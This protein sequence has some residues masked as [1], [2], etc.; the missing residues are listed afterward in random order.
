MFKGKVVIVTGSSSGIGAGTAIKYAKEGAA[1]VVLHG[2][3]Q[4]QLEKVKKDCEAASH[5]QGK[6]HVVVGDISDPKVQEKLVNETVKL[7]GQ[8]DVLVNNAGISMQ[9]TPT[10]ECPIDV[11]DNLF[12]INVRSLILTTQLAIPHLV[13]TKGSIVNIS[14]VAALKAHPVFTYYNMTKI[15]VDHYTRC[16]AVE[17]GPQGVRVNSVQP[18]AIP[19]TD[20]AARSLA[21]APDFEQFRAMIEGRTPMRRTG[22]VDEVANTILF[23]SSSCASF[24][25]GTCTTVDGG[26]NLS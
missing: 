14:S 15:A 3:R 26:L 19:D 23:L 1:A 8:L 6:V 13:K 20:L 22:A 24:I 21:K 9:A 2:R 12:S 10:A 4:E 17:L 7:F 5:G 18:G 11:F 25:T 16:L